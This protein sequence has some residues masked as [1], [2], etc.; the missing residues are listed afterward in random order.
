MIAHLMSSNILYPIDHSMK[1]PSIRIIDGQS[2]NN[3]MVGIDQSRSSK[4]F[5]DRRLA[6]A[7]IRYQRSCTKTDQII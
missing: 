2:M 7:S 5:C 6:D 4:L 1:L 3:N